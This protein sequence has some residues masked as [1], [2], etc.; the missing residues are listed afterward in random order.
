MDSIC[1]SAVCATIASPAM[2]AESPVEHG[3]VLHAALPVQLQT[4]RITAPDPF[5]PRPTVQA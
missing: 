5:P 4:G 3:H 2:Q 1:V